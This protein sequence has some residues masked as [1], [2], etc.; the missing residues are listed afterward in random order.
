[1]PPPDE[2]EAQPL[3]APATPT[4]TPAVSSAHVLT[5]AGGDLFEFG[6]T[7]GVGDAVRLQHPL[8][9]VAVDGAVFI[10]DTYNHKIKRLDAARGAVKTFAGTG[11]PG[12]TDGASPSFYEP[13]GLSYA[14]GKLYVADTN[15]HAVRVVDARTGQTA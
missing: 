13:G 8:G 14:G 4:P 12:Q 11:R 10:A 2:D 1:M 7:D 15:N 3:A 5:L 6:D 9:V